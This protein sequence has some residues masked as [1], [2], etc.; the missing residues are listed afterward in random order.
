MVKYRVLA[1]TSAAVLTTGLA[2]AA[3]GCTSR[4]SAPGGS[5]E[6]SSASA[7]AP[8]AAASSAPA[9]AAPA[10][11]S[12]PR[13]I[14][15]KTGAAYEETDGDA[16]DRDVYGD[17]F[18]CGVTGAANEQGDRERICVYTFATAQRQQEDLTQ[19]GSGDG[20]V[21]VKGNL[22]DVWVIPVTDH[23]GNFTFPV[24]PKEIALRVHG[25]VAG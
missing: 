23:E 6:R 20:E 25:T 11:P 7:A 4:S 5:D 17:K 1:A 24:T 15:L 12:D 16:V 3:A 21:T 9:A 10:R 19:P 22:W 14:F 18:L 13:P 8:V 2:L